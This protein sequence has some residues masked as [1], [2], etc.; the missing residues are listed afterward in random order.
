MVPKLGGGLEENLDHSP[1]YSDMTVSA[2]SDFHI[3]GATA[4]P[5]FILNVFVLVMKTRRLLC[6]KAG[7]SLKCYSSLGTAALWSS[8]SSYPVVPD[9]LFP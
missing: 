4:W 5:V 9:P 2:H 8:P 3:C 7:L 6:G 1:L